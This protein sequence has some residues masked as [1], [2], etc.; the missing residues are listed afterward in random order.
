MNGARSIADAPTVLGIP[1][2]EFTPRVRDA[3]MKLMGEVDTLRQELQNQKKRLTQLASEADQDVLVPCLNRRAFVRE[4]SRLLSF[5]ERYDIPASLVF[6]DL[7]NFKDIN[8]RFGHAAGDAALMQVCE[9]LQGQIRESDVL[10]R[11]GGDE[12]GLILAKAKLPEA[13]RKAE[14][15]SEIIKASPL[16]WGGQ[17]IKLSFTTG[18][19]EFRTGESPAE[20]MAR[21]DRAMYERKARSRASAV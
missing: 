4:M 21:A 6:V 10:G 16:V 1:A 18:A 9:V 7:D 8:D 3:I 13:E 17:A 11:L 19:Y 14:M 5:V 20:T 15:L 12:F 2:Q